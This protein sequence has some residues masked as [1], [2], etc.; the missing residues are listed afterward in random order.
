MFLPVQ[1]FLRAVRLLQ[2]APSPEGC[3]S[4]ESVDEQFTLESLERPAKDI[5]LREEST[6]APASV[7]AP[8]APLRNKVLKRAFDA[9]GS[10]KTASDEQRKRSRLPVI[11]LEKGVAYVL[12]CVGFAT[13]RPQ[14]LPSSASG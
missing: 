1:L 13:A 14:T 8:A 3:P 4:Q 12:A 7:S 5:L 9:V 6:P 11:N 2:D 10:V